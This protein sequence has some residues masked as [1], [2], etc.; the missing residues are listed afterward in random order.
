MTGNGCYLIFEC[1]LMFSVLWIIYW[2]IIYS[3]V[4]PI[5]TSL[6]QVLYIQSLWRASIPTSHASKYIYL[7]TIPEHDSKLQKDTILEASL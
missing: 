5:A 4:S 7:G 6:T 1:N 2:Y 3:Q